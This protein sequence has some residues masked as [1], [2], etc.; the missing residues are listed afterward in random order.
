MVESKETYTLK[1]K[2]G[3][4][5]LEA[6]DPG[7]NWKPENPPDRY[8]LLMKG[9]TL[10]DVGPRPNGPGY[11]LYERQYYQQAQAPMKQ[12]TRYVSPV[13]VTW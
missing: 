2:R 8:T 11:P 10:V 12:L 13:T 9:N 4:R 6:I 3:D 5:W 1:W 7:R